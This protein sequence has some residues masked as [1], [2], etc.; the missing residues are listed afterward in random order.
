M[1]KLAGTLFV[2]NGNSQDYCYLESIRSLLQLCEHTFVVDAGSN[3]GTVDVIWDSFGTNKEFTF[4]KLDSAEWDKQKGKEKLNYFTNIAIRA[5][6]EE[7]YEYQFNLQ[8]DEILHEK[9]YPEIMKAINTGEE[10][11]MTKRINLWKTPFQQ[12][13]VPHDRLPCST[14]IVRLS[15][16]NYRS[17]GDAESIAVDNVNFDY[18]DKIDIW[19][20]GFVRNR[21]IMKGK[22]IHMQEQVFGIDHDKKLDG[23]DYFDPDRWFNPETELKL[24]DYPHPYIMKEWIKTR[25]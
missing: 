16:T 24:I 13:N 3:D 22:V 15:K 10:G 7:G 23:L 20:Y 25:P 19:H 6:Q 14:E 12:L 4:I 2:Y 8:A 1:K 9:S 11:F 18:I 5:A 17:Y 21:N